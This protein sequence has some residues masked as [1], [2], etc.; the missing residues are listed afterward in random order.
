MKAVILAAGGGGR[1][2]PLTVHRPKALLS[3]AGHPLI[4]HV[5]ASL[6]GAGLR[7]MLVVLGYRSEMLQEHLG[8]GSRLGVHIDYVL[9]PQ[10]RWGNARSLWCAREAVGGQPFVLAMGDHLCSARLVQ[11]LYA[12]AGACSLL[13]ADFSD[14]GPERTEEATKVL[15]SPDRRVLA[16]GKGLPNWNALDTGLFYCLPAIFDLLSP[17]LREGELSRVFSALARGDGGGGGLLA[18]DVTGCFW[19]DVDTEADL[20]LAEALLGR[21]AT[22]LA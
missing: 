11:T 4:D 16:I 21:D 10:Y 20:R 13:A 22:I 18:C 7:D 9:N 2:G 1:L 19:L 6:A 5:V 14:L 12:S 3:V 17:E 15:V 8:D